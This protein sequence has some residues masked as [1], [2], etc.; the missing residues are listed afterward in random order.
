[1]IRIEI[2]SDGTKDGIK[3]F[4]M[5]GTHERVIEECG[6]ALYNIIYAFKKQYRDIE[7]PNTDFEYI[8]NVREYFQKIMDCAEMNAA[9]FDYDESKGDLSEDEIQQLDSLHNSYLIFLNDGKEEPPE[10]DKLF[11]DV[12]YKKPD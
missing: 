4:E 3:H 7:Y 2:D 6:I 10:V 5:K 11:M 1:M 9:G 12:R 8:G